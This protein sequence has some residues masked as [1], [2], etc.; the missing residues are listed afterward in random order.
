M[1]TKRSVARALKWLG[2][3]VGVLAIVA[4]L[5]WLTQSLW[6]GTG[7]WRS[8]PEGDAPRSQTIDDERFADA[9]QRA[10]EIIAAHRERYGFPALTAAVSIGGD[11][12]WTGAVG[13]ADLDA[14]TPATRDTVLR[15]GSTSKAVTATALA[16]LVDR[17]DMSLDA[18]LSAYSDDWSNPAWPELTLRQLASHTAGLPEYDDNGDFMGGLVTL[19]GCVHYG[20]V[21]ESL[22]IFDGTELLYEPGTDFAYTSFDVSLIGAAI[23]AS[24]G[25]PFLDVLS[26][27][28]FEPLGMGASGGDHDGRERPHL[29]RFYETEGGRARTWRP[30]DLSQR[31]P[32]GG[33]V[34]TSAEL[35]RLGGAWMDPAFITPET[36]AAMWTPQVLSDGEVNEQY[37]ALGW[38]FSPHDTWPGDGSRLLPMAHHGGITKG[39]MSWLVVYPDFELSIAVNIN[40]RAEDFGAFVSV[41]DELALLFLERLEELGGS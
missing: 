27:E 18:P 4:L 28:V 19:C 16:R 22:A 13:W 39:A 23:A 37:Y 40:T 8:L 34:S 32:G 31:W 7:A 24:Q 26:R 17:G 6:D 9:G 11:L 35:A 15:I 5:A 2:R 41:E 38:R 29:A 12:A 25:R 30:F 21:R 36:R 14:S 33:L 1:G 20:S 3:G 10:L